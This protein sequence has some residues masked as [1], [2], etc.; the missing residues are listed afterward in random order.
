MAAFAPDATLAPRPLPGR[1]GTWR[2]TAS[3]APFKVRDPFAA[4]RLLLA[5]S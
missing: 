1:E 5:A 4:R 2:R 3:D